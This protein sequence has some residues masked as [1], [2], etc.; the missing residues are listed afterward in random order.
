MIF[1]LMLFYPKS[2]PEK[3]FHI[4]RPTHSC[5]KKL[6]VCIEQINS[7]QTC[8]K[9]WATHNPHYYWDSELVDPWHVWLCELI[10]L[11]TNCIWQ[12]FTYELN[13]SPSFVLYLNIMILFSFNMHQLNWILIFFMKCKCS[14]WILIW[15]R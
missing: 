12:K 10:V 8:W 7:I 4:F 6:L 3:M 15:K 9:H 14:N 2:Q 1:C 13:H 5:G 11:V